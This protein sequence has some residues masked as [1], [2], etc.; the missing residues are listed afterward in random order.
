MVDRL[1]L[2]IP[3]ELRADF[4]AKMVSHNPAETAL[5]NDLNGLAGLHG[6]TQRP[7][8]TLLNNDGP[9]SITIDSLFR[10][11]AEGRWLNTPG[12]DDVTAA[13]VRYYLSIGV[14]ALDQLRSRLGRYR[15]DLQ[16]D[17]VGLLAA[18][19]PCDIDV[20]RAAL[21]IAGTSSVLAALP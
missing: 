20:E 9:G 21:A 11:V 16:S 5:W 7:W 12:G 17:L 6:W 4:G 10:A 3:G 14:P 19:P 8:P 15:A 2:G 1:T 13:L 18:T